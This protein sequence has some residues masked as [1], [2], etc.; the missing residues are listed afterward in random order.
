MS[1]DARFPFF[2]EGEFEDLRWHVI[3]GCRLA[4]GGTSHQDDLAASIQTGRDRA[5][6]TLVGFYSAGD[7]GVFMHMGSKTRVHC[8]LETPRATGPVDH[9]IIAAGTRIGF[10]ALGDPSPPVGP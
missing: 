10:P 2:L 1:L 6:A 9:V 4:D 8:V 5:S 3:D 7:Q